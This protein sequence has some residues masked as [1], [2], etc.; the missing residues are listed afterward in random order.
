[1]SARA[2]M[3]ANI[4]YLRGLTNAGT[5]DY[6]LGT[7]AYWDGDQMQA[8]LDRNRVDFYRAAFQKIQ[9]YEGGTVVYKIYQSEFRFIESGTNFEL[10]DAEGNTV[11]T[12]LYTLDAERGKVTF[13][14]DTGGSTYYMTGRSFL[15]EPAAAE[16]WRSKAANVSAY[17]DIKTISQSLSR[18]Q[19]VKQFLEM[20]DYFD[21]QSGIMTV[22]MFRSDDAD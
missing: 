9:Q 3:S 16:I 1:M 22:E 2:G 19:M 8:V 11:G 14:S 20:A 12:A 4:E 7:V 17:Y 5:A 10:E 18:S 15:M 6:T 21:A 13:A